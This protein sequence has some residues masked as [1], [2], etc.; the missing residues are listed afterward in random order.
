VGAVLEFVV[1]GALAVGSVAT[2]VYFG[3]WIKPG[4]HLP[5]ADPEGGTD[6]APRGT[7]DRA[8]RPDSPS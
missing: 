3:R 5:Q 6:D 2:I 1:T 8:L 4:Q 7:W